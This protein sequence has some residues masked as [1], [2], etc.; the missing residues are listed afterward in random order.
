MKFG[1]SEIAKANIGVVF[2]IIYSLDNTQP[3]FPSVRR[4]RLKPNKAKGKNMAARS[5]EN[6]RAARLRELADFPLARNPRKLDFARPL[7][8][9]T[10]GKKSC[11]W[12]I[13]L[14]ATDGN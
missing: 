8:R 6:S 12:S 9:W 7:A 10:K 14:S 1:S 13:Y 2:I 4:A 5:L 3:L 11:K